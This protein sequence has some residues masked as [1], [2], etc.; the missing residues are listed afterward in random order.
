MARHMQ[1]RVEDDRKHIWFK[2][3][4]C[5]HIVEVD[6]CVVTLRLATKL[7]VRDVDTGDIVATIAKILN[8]SASEGN[9]YK[10]VVDNC[11]QKVNDHKEVKEDMASRR[12]PSP[13]GRPAR[14]RRTS[15]RTCRASSR[16]PR[17]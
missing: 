13:G 10:E 17:G 14:S 3:G 2:N 7:A 11:E 12:L 9:D 8:A 15:P 5:R 1:R 16:E 6:N 4:S